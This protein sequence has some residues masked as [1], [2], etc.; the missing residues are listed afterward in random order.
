[1]PLIVYLWAREE[2]SKTLPAANLSGKDPRSSFRIQ[3]RSTGTKLMAK[4]IQNFLY[5]AIN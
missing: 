3:K 4:D 1:M 5:L 2:R